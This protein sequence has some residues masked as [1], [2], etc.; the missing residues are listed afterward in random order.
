MADLTVD[1]SNHNAVPDIGAALAAADGVILKATEGGG[2]S[3][4][5]FPLWA[6]SARNQGSLVTPYDFAHPGS[7]TPEQQ[8]DYY[9]DYV[10]GRYGVPWRAMLDF[11]VTS[12]SPVGTTQHALRWGQRC[13][14]RWPD[15]RRSLYTY[16]YFAPSFVA[17][18]ALAQ[19]F[20]LHIAAYP[21]GYSGVPNPDTIRP[22]SPIAPWS[23]WVAWQYTSIGRWPGVDGNVDV[24]IL[25]P[26]WHTGGPALPEEAELSAL[27]DQIG[28]IELRA[29]SNQNTLGTMSEIDYEQYVDWLYRGLL[30]RSS[31]ADGS[32]SV[33]VQQLVNGASPAQV[34]KAIADSGEAKAYA[35]KARAPVT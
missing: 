28:R 9:A 11:E 1:L 18:P 12:T 15:A 25:S 19:M 5:W 13:A 33:W 24:N 8:F 22:Q 17:D 26:A 30:G 7:G 29:T 34:R 21:W 10:E 32:S 2:F 31:L 4:P 27:S 20:E 35:S 14:Q 23:S 6:G 3:D 16:P